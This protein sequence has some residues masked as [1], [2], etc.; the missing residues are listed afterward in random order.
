MTM[1]QIESLLKSFFKNVTHWVGINEVSTFQNLI[2]L[3]IKMDLA[4][5]VDM[6][7]HPGDRVA[8]L[9]SNDKLFVPATLEL[10]G[11][12]TR[13][14]RRLQWSV[15]FHVQTIY[16]Y[17]GRRLQCRDEDVTTLTPGFFPRVQ[18]RGLSKHIY[19][20]I[21]IEHLM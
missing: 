7:N 16:I 20:S 19:F 18:V 4:Y 14:E 1:E 10:E 3:M 17:I 13:G 8:N 9:H 2:Q 11:V 5:K 21:D 12:V 6:A 15:K